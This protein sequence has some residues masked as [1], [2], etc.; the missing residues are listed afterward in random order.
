MPDY[1]LLVRDSDDVLLDWNRGGNL[2]GDPDGQGATVY[3]GVTIGSDPELGGTYDGAT[4]TPPTPPDYFDVEDGGSPIADGGTVQLTANGSDTL[5][6]TAQKK[7]GSDDSDMVGSD[8]TI[9]VLPQ[10]VIPID[11]MEVTLDTSDGA[12]DFTIGPFDSGW[13]GC[14]LVRLVDD[15]GALK[16]RS[17]MLE[18]S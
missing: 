7:D 18:V 17:F 12:E 11:K 5:T 2:D 6:L 8:E 13:K 10:A 1:N 15:A 4:Y 16:G 3:E 9:K 14:V